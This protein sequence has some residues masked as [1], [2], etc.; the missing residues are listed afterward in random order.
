MHWKQFFR[1]LWIAKLYVCLNCRWNTKRTGFDIEFAVQSFRRVSPQ[2]F[3]DGL[4]LRET[5]FDYNRCIAI[6]CCVS[7]FD[8]SEHPGYWHESSSRSLVSMPNIL[9]WCECLR[10]FKELSPAAFMPWC[11]MFL[12]AG[13]NKNIWNSCGFPV[14]RLFL[15]T[16]VKN[17]STE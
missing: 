4:P 6:F 5:R 1:I 9:S 2:L 13:S 16:S 10:W 3:V 12:A 11:T 7:I 14:H 17:Y 8:P 15:T